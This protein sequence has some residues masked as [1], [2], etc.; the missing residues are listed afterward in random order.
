MKPSIIIS[1]IV[2]FFLIG[3]KSKPKDPAEGAKQLVE[4]ISESLENHDESNIDKL[5]QDYW[6]Y[7]T[8]E[9]PQEFFYGM[10]IALWNDKYNNLVKYIVNNDF[11]VHPIYKQYLTEILEY[12]HKEGTEMLEEVIAEPSKI[13]GFK[14]TP[15]SGAQVFG[16]NLFLDY[17]NDDY[18]DANKKIQ[19]EFLRLRQ[20]TEWEKT[21]YA[22][23][24]MRFWQT[25]GEYG[26]QS[27]S[28]L[29]GNGNFD[30]KTQNDFVTL[31]LESYADIY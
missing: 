10:R 20:C 30:N 11:K 16:F 25:N 18:D 27:M 17:Q 4:K 9:N 26:K 23:A 22:N 24:L 21:E 8:K 14:N 2:C 31:I 19:S 15:S 29:T 28:M 6:D 13:N 5:M 1:L 7:Y 3:C 12:T